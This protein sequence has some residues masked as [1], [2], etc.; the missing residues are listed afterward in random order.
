MILCLMINLSI[1]VV[2]VVVAYPLFGDSKDLIRDLEKAII[3]LDC[4]K[5]L[6]IR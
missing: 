1:F 2:V 6:K 3:L 5:K 4:K